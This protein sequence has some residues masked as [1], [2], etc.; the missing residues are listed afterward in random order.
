[1]ERRTLEELVDAANAIL[2]RLQIETADGR[3]RPRVDARTVRYYST[4]G[5]VDPPL[6]H[7]GRQAHYGRRHLL[8]VVATKRLQ[9]AGSTLNEVALALASAPTPALEALA[10]VADDAPI[11]PTNSALG[12]QAASRPR[13][14]LEIP[15]G[16]DVTLTIPAH[17]PAPLAL[18]IAALRRAATPILRLVDPRLPGY[19]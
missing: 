17:D 6:D 19:G 18:D 9:A 14:R 8:Q 11:P 16:G 15:L 2:D 4:L 13:H 10:A 12:V 1:V 3:A 5:L 7:R